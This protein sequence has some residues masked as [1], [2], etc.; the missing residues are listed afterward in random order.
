MCP[1]QSKPDDSRSENISP[2]NISRDNGPAPLNGASGNPERENSH[3]SGERPGMRQSRKDFARGREA[4]R[5]SL[6]QTVTELDQDIL[7]LLLRR[8]NLLE[9]MKGRKGHLDSSEEKFLRE[10]WQAAVARV[11]RD[12]ALSGRFFSMMQDLTFLPKPEERGEGDG[13]RPGAQRRSAFNLAPPPKAVRIVLDAP[14]DD[15]HSRCWLYLASAAGQ[16]LEFGPALMNDPQVDLVRALNQL[17]GSLAREGDNMLARPGQALDYPD[18]IV[19][20]GDAPFNFHL[21]LAHYLGR[22]SRVKFTGESDLKLADFSS[23][24][25]ALPELGARLTPVVPKCNG[26]PA[27][28][29]CSGILPPSFALGPSL[30]AEFGLALV[31]AAPFYQTPFAVDLSAHPERAEIL[32]RAVPLLEECGFVFRLQGEA[33]SLE[34]GA[35]RIPARPKLPVDATLSASLLAF[36]LPHGGSVRLAGSLA[37]FPSGQG[38]LQNLLAL[39]LPVRQGDGGV[40]LELSGPFLPGPEEL[41]R[42]TWPAESRPLLCALLAMRPLRGEAGAPCRLLDDLAGEPEAGDFFHALGLGT[43]SAGLTP[44][45]GPTPPYNAPSA[46]WALAFALAA[47]GRGAPK[48]LSL[49]N[50]GIMT[51]LWPAFWAFYNGLPAPQPKGQDQ[52]APQKAEKKRR[53]I[54]TS[55]VAV[56]PEIREEDW[57]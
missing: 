35:P 9:K 19:H 37:A 26:L 41:G 12:A 24:R 36:A 54:I 21:L 5:K 8:S 45:P 1:A 44:A 14:L 32:A 52:P 49:G 47:L 13:P 28:L 30:P 17:G 23:L 43:S 50:P 39:G 15:I 56:P 25:H 31:L 6:R 38:L 2:D 27:R 10:S 51:N 20:L 57:E 42:L 22:P 7:H 48:G 55:A 11:S 16:Q 29:E 3:H 34:P 46:L 18:K 33:I 40:S 4:P 53:R